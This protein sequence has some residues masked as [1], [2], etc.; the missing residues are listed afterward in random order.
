M[1][2][3]PPSPSSAP[4]PSRAKRVLRAAGYTALALTAWT[5]A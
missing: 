5:A 2:T 4:A 1:T 3:P